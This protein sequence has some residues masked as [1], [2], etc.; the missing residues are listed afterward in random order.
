LSGAAVQRFKIKRC[1][2]RI[3]NL[4]G[5]KEDVF[6]ILMHIKQLRFKIYYRRT[7]NSNIVGNGGE[8]K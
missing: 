7:P 3:C 2:S 4:K 6:H 1:P 8:Q 5:V